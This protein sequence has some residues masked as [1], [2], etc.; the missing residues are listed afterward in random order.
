MRVHPRARCARVGD[1]AR[2]D[3]GVDWDVRGELRGGG[4]S[5][6]GGEGLDA[7]VVERGE[8]RENGTWDE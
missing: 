3:G 7:R 6:R 1:D 8:R 2:G 5:T 4:E